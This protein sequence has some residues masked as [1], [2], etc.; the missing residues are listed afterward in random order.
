MHNTD[1]SDSKVLEQPISVKFDSNQYIREFFLLSW[2]LLLQERYTLE[3][4]QNK[5]ASIDG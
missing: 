4:K 3:W 5:D 1:K 2:D